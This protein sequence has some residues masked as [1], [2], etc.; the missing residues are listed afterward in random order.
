MFNLLF[1]ECNYTIYNYNNITA[2]VLKNYLIKRTYSFKINTTLNIL[3]EF[4]FN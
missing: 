3:H 4:R 2:Y 1:A